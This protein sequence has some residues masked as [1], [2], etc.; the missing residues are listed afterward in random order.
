MQNSS[1]YELLKIE[2][3]AS[4]HV[5]KSA[6]KSLALKYHPDRRCGG[7]P[8][9]LSM[10]MLNQAYEILSDPE[11]RKNYDDILLTSELNGF[12]KEKSKDNDSVNCS[13]QTFWIKTSIVKFIRWVP[14]KNSNIKLLKSKYF[15]LFAT[16][17]FVSVVLFCMNV[18]KLT[19]P[20]KN[21]EISLSRDIYSNK[22][23]QLFNK[24]IIGSCQ[25]HAAHKYQNRQ[26]PLFP[27]YIK[28]PVITRDYPSIEVYNSHVK[29]NI[30]GRLV[31]VA[32]QKVSVLREFYIPAGMS[33]K[34][35]GLE[36]GRYSIKYFN[37]ETGCGFKSAPFDMSDVEDIEKIKLHRQDLSDNDATP[38]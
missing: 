5:I 22:E 28:E 30:I 23:K 29:E 17:G 12:Y 7:E 14:C 36:A 1:Y 6:Y 33:F 8:S 19:S 21:S 13:A 3:D 16:S 31:S 26:L 10:S 18:S 11:K 27:T 15:L 35:N 38:Q 34:I 37:V 2:R 9:D 24:S 4:P 32:D 20:A 25:Y